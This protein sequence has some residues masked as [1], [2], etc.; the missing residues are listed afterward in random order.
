MNIDSNS[1][2]YSVNESIVG[3]LRSMGFWAYGL[4]LV[5]VVT[6]MSVPVPA[7]GI[8]DGR[9]LLAAMQRPVGF[10]STLAGV[11]VGYHTVAGIERGSQSDS[12]ET[13]LARAVAGKSLGLAVP[14]L[15]TV[16]VAGVLNWQRY[17]A[18]DPVSFVSFGLVAVAYLVATVAVGVA[19]SA[20]AVRSTPA[21]LLGATYVVGALTWEF[22][23]DAA[24]RSVTGARYLVRGADPSAIAFFLFRLSPLSAYMVAT[25]AVVGVGNGALPAASILDA[26]AGVGAPAGHV[27]V[28][29]TTYPAGAT[30]PY[31]SPAFA[32]VVLGAWTA[33]AFAVARW[34][35]RR[36]ERR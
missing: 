32:V 28:V 11:L 4:V 21:F 8:Q 12:G 35:F 36:V 20:I 26:R 24:Y 34:R 31:L 23:F 2:A 9:L 3:Y 33:V 13:V 15:A 7:S 17:G 5:V 19:A 6:N 1:S 30:P 18:V 22:L 29:E 27:P 10:F 25:N 16:A 14:L